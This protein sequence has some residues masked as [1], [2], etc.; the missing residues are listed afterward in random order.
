MGPLLN[1]DLMQFV[2]LIVWYVVTV[3][4][5]YMIIC[6]AGKPKWLALFLVIPIAGFVCHLDTG[7]WQMASSKPSPLAWNI[8]R[9]R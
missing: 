7:L 9:S 6:R 1:P 4:P 5:V 8:T 3:I 2:P